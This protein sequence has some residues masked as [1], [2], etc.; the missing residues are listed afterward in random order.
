MNRKQKALEE[1]YKAPAP[2]YA[3]PGVKN[4]PWK[5]YTPDLV[6][7]KRRKL[8]ELLKS[9]KTDVDY[10]NDYKREAEYLL[11]ECASFKTLEE[12]NNYKHSISI[13]FIFGPQGPT[14]AAPTPT[15]AM[16]FTWDVHTGVAL[17]KLYNSLY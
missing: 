7:R 3:N 6:T 2:K 14:R 10:Y 16:K 5:V 11:K 13:S 15:K 9:T 4:S 12:W 17:T 8:A 1:R